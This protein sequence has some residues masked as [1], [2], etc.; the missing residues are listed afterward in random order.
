MPDSIESVR[1]QIDE[2]KDTEDKF[3]AAEEWAKG[4]TQPEHVER[5][6]DLLMAL[7]LADVH[8]Q[9]HLN[10]LNMMVMILTALVRRAGSMK[11]IEVTPEELVERIE[12]LVIEQG[13]DGGVSLSITAKPDGDSSLS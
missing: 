4:V 9:D 1:A 7:H 11:L 5:I 3:R 2:C 6:R 8:A 10:S 13:D 12:R